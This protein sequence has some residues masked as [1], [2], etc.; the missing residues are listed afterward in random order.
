[1]LNVQYKKIFLLLMLF[2]TYKQTSGGRS[3]HKLC[4]IFTTH[5]L[6]NL[7][8]MHVIYNSSWK[9]QFIISKK[10]LKKYSY[11]KEYNIDFTLNINNICNWSSLSFEEYE[12]LKNKLN[13]LSKKYKNILLKISNV[14]KIHAPVIYDWYVK[15]LIDKDIY[16]LKIVPTLRKLY[17]ED[18]KDNIND[19]ISIHIRRGDLAEKLITSG[20]NFS[21][22]K[23]MID[24][25]NNHFDIDINIYCE[26]ENYSDISKLKNCKNTN[27][28]LGGTK[29]FGKHFNKMVNSRVLIISP[30]SLCL[31]AGLI[32]RGLVLIDKKVIKWRKTVFNKSNLVFESFNNISEKIEI[33]EK[34]FKNT[35]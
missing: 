19:S 4:D 14:Y 24:T 21:Y 10:S 9:N 27:L 15:K 20:F 1:M 35:N 16:N 13:K 31:F 17:F 33:I 30:S 11:N 29:L 6:A 2:I 32:N 23:N 5:I 34:Q 26:N 28:F 3:G 22:Y 18:N 7:L 25:L 8:D 12:K